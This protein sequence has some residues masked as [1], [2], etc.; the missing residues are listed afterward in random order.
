MD[1]IMKTVTKAV[2][3]IRTR[4]LNHRHFTLFLKDLESEF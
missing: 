1:E 3:F 4:A 2:N